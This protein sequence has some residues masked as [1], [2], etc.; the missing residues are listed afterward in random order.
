MK[1][2]EQWL[3]EMKARP[4]V[5]ETDLLTIIKR[6]QDDARKDALALP[7]SMID[8]FNSGDGTYRP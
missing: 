6:I 5:T 1:T 4:C 8:A 3:E 7:S 2:P